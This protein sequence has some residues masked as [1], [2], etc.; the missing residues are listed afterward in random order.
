MHA[1]LKKGVSFATFIVCITFVKVLTETIHRRGMKTHCNKNNCMI[2]NSI[3]IYLV[4]MLGLSVLV[5]NIRYTLELINIMG[6]E[7]AIATNPTPTCLLVMG[8]VIMK[9]VGK[10]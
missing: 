3:R 10:L 1:M 2:P 6:I 9:E 4:N 8:F 5:K 7:M